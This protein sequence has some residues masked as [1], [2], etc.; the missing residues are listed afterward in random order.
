[1]FWYSRWF[2]NRSW[3][4]FVFLSS[5]AELAG[6]V[7][8]VLRSFYSAHV[9]VF[10]KIIWAYPERV[11]K[12]ISNSY[13]MFVFEFPRTVRCSHVFNVNS[14]WLLSCCQ[15]CLQMFPKCSEMHQN[16]HQVNAKSSWLNSSYLSSQVLIP[17]YTVLVDV[18]D[19][20]VR[21]RHYE[22]CLRWHQDWFFYKPPTAF[23]PTMTVKLFDKRYISLLTTTFLLLGGK[24]FGLVW[25]RFGGCLGRIF[26]GCSE[27]LLSKTPYK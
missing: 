22:V 11:S 18:S 16:D 23:Y 25:E 3:C 26:E 5:L 20:L 9:W 4:V 19:A 6:I 21:T 13:P 27:V 15:K 17:L 1:M 7:W 24:V 8:F 14:R 2:Q 10:V 12:V